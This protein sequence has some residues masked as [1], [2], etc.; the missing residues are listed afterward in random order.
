MRRRCGCLAGATTC[1]I[2][3]LLAWQAMKG[4]ANEEVDVSKGT[5]NVEAKTNVVG[6]KHVCRFARGGFPSIIL[7][8]ATCGRPWLQRYTR[9]LALT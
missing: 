9:R 4:P 2:F 1:V 7:S 3:T 6:S 5:P 8:S